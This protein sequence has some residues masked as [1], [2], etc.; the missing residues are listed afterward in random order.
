MSRRALRRLRGEQRGQEPLGPGALQFDLRDDD[1]AEEEGPK[2]ELG[3]RRPGGAGKEGVRV[4]NRFE[5]INI[6]DLE[7]DPVVNGERSG[8]ALTDAAAPGNKG[9][10]QRGNTESKTD[11]DVTETAPSEQSHAS[12]KLRKKKKKQKN[13]KSSTGEASENG[14]EDIDRILERIEDSTGLNR[15]GPAPLSSRKHVLY[16]EHR[17]LNPDTELKR[18]FG[19]RAILG[20]QRPRQRQRVYPKCTW[21]TTPKSTWPRYSKPG[22]SMRLLESKKGLS[23]FAFEHSEEYQQAQHKF[24]VA[25]ES[26]EPN[27]IVVLLQT[28]PYH[29]DSLL[30]LSDACRFQEDQEMARDLVERALYS[31]ECAFH[32]LFS[33]TSGA[34][35]LDYRRPENRS[36]YLALYKQMSF[37]EKRGCPRTALEYCKLIL[38]LEPDE[39][40][41]CM[42]LLID[43]LALRARNYEYL[44]RLFQEWEAHR[45]LS[46]LPNFAFSVPLAYFLLSQQT[47]LPECER[48]SAR[49]KASLLIQQALTMFPGVLLPLLESCSVRPDA[50]VSSHRF[51]GPSAE[52]SQ[53]PALS[54]L[55]NLYL[56]R[57]HFLW[58]EPATMSWLEENVHEVLQ[59]VDAGDPAV[60]A[61]ENRRKVLYQ[62]APRN[63]HRHVI[64]S[65]IKEAVAALP[66]DVTTQSVMGFDPLPPSDT[67]YSYVRPERLSPISH[68]NTIALFFRSLLPNYTMEGE[69]PEEGV[70]GGLNRNQGLN[71]LM[72]AVRDMMANFHLNDLEAPHEDDAEG[73]GEWD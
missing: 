51:F 58:K 16:V 44:I 47:D 3:V 67:I 55:V 38:S 42:L 10:G 28:S 7:D 37:L 56:G 11:G 8:C 23:F 6:D 66:P 26:M 15:P 48:S 31:M 18:Y 69:R 30:Q 72:L 33:L 36:F 65:E 22:L 53:P 49:Q 54:Q 2:R 70:A 25:V 46:Q 24:L 19:A 41:L 57:S 52:I 9:R 1:D 64:L 45:N 39:D 14:L 62:R 27:N 61:C 13:K 60:E 29:V 59:A 50:S 20:E 35:R 71:R 40:P 34:C 4:N 21:L 5:L 32:P 43:H 12:G 63:I 73:E 68:G 17:H